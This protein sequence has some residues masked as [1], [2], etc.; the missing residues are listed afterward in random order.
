MSIILSSILSPL[1]EGRIYVGSN[2]LSTFCWVLFC[3]Y[4]HINTALGGSVGL[5][6]LLLDNYHDEKEVLWRKNNDGRTMPAY[7]C[8]SAHWLMVEAGN[9]LVKQQAATTKSIC[10]CA[11]ISFLF[12]QSQ[13]VFA[14]RFLFYFFKANLYLLSDFFSIFSKSHCI[15]AQ[16]CFVILQSQIVF[17][18]RF[19]LYFFK[20]NLYLCSDFFCVSF[21]V[22]HFINID[23][24]HI[25]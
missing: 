12:L 24:L 22:L 20:V 11:Q 10:I 5:Y 21:C 19:L 8:T 25:T 9:G 1:I 2:V 16:I 13:F 18:L 17:A 6:S 15:C 14:V 4:F 23:T 7:V 3:I